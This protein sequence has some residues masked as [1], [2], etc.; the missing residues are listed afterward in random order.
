MYSSIYNDK[1]I[2][3]KKFFYKNL[4]SSYHFSS[5]V[6][7]PPNEYK[8]NFVGEL[9]KH[10]KPKFDLTTIYINKKSP[11]Y[12]INCKSENSLKRILKPKKKSLPKLLINNNIINNSINFKKKKYILTTHGIHLGN[13]GVGI[14]IV[15][16]NFPYCKPKLK[17][18]NTNLNIRY[19]FKNLNSN[20]TDLVNLKK[21]E[22]LFIKSLTNIHQMLNKI[23][24]DNERKICN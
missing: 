2:D 9:K 7:T 3:T 12:S 5:T 14:G 22:R 13:T 19:K 8:N 4:I 15:D 20:K 24:N 1:R 18:S 23:K 17:C 6:R 16:L 21:S 10:I 11:I